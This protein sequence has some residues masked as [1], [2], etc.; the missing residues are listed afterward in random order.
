MN[1]K[2]AALSV[3]PVDSHK[4]WLKD[5]VAHAGGA[6]SIDFPVISDESRDIST[7]YGMIDPWAFDKK[8]LP[9]T[10]R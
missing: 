6:I 1:C 4:E 9:L 7:A 8:D 3:D 5:A 2:I 10:I